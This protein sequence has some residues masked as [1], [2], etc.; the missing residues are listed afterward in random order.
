[1]VVY[2]IMYLET[3]FASAYLAF[4]PHLSNI[5]EPQNVHYVTVN[6]EQKNIHNFLTLTN[7]HGP[8]I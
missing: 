3:P 5:I 2:N 7:I 1:M 4:S 8:A 6:F